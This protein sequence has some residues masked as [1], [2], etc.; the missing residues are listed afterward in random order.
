MV[1]RFWI[2]FAHCEGGREVGE[3]LLL[4]A[5]MDDY[6]TFGVGN[7]HRLSCLTMA[8]RIGAQMRGIMRPGRGYVVWFSF[9][10]VV[11]GGRG[12]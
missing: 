4:L 2:P 5:W 8:C 1:L 7:G 10:H 11:R 3:R 6:S 9:F 12:S